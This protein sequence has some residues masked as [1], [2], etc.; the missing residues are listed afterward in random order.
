MAS[1]KVATTWERPNLEME[2]TFS[3]CGRPAMAISTGRVICFSISSGPRFGATVLICTCTGVVSGKA[4]TG[5][6]R[7]AQAPAAKAAVKKRTVNSRFLMTLS[8]SRSSIE[9]PQ[10]EGL[11]VLQVPCVPNVLIRPVGPGR[12]LGLVKKA[13]NDPHKKRQAGPAALPT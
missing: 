11:V 1:A 8:I 3:S 7:S 6:R 9:Y 13:I 4:S 12:P 2:R 10:R 5:R